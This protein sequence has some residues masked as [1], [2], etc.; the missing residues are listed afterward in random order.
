[1]V[2]NDKFS[3]GTMRRKKQTSEDKDSSSSFT[4]SDDDQH[5]SSCAS[6]SP[7]PSNSAVKKQVGRPPKVPGALVHEKISNKKNYQQ[8][9]NSTS[10]CKVK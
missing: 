2:T 9:K 7:V 10:G 5:N 3:T 1:M 4:E 6:N 8:K